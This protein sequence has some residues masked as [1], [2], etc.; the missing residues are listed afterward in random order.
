LID[1]VAAV[2]AVAVPMSTDVTCE[3]AGSIPIMIIYGKKDPIA[4]LE[5]NVEC[6]LMTYWSNIL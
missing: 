6:V 2:V 3:P 5:G 4:H 1:R